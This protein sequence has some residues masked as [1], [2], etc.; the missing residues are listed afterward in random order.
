MRLFQAGVN[1]K[2][3]KEFTGHVSDAVDKYQ[4][5]SEEQRENLSKI[6][7]GIKPTGSMAKAPKVTEPSLEV[8][9]KEN[10]EGVQNSACHCK[11]QTLNI[12]DTKSLG[13]MINS[14]VS[15]RKG[16]KVSLKIEV[17]YS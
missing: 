1:R 6:I 9:V 10:F 14:L 12:S 11:N 13:E 4:I 16:C 15:A 17:K 5:T 7:S 2:V 8:M 3:I